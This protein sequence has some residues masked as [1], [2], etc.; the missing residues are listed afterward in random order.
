MSG[1]VTGVPSPLRD[2]D[3][4]RLYPQT[5]H[6]PASGG[7]RGRGGVADRSYG[8]HALLEKP[9]TALVTVL[10]GE[11]TTMLPVVVGSWNQ[12]P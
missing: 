8:V 5:D 7:E 2:V 9:S 6:G 4:R 1:L 12:K 11:Q 3:M 10:P